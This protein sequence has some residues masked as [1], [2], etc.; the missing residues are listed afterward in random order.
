MQVTRSY[1]SYLLHAKGRH[2]IHSPFVYE[3]V[4]KCLTTKID[5]N[6]KVQLKL[7]YAQL[8]KNNTLLTIN[9]LGAGSNFTQQQKTVSRIFKNASSKGIYGNLLY[10]LAGYFKPSNILELG[11]SLGVGTVHLKNGFKNSSVHTVEGCNEIHQS[12]TEQ[13]KYWD[14]KDVA[15][16]NQS[17]ANFIPNFTEKVDLI[18]LDGHHEQNATKRYLEQLLNNAHSETLFILDDIRW[19]KDMWNCW[20]SICTDE[21]FHVT[22]DIGRMGLFWLRPHQTKEHFVLRPFIIKTPWF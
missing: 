8:R 1:W 12:A 20:E 11:T 19:S 2:G 6:F 10:R 14:F 17:F 22:I 15:L 21:R 3:L 4:D 9:D 16:Y 18:Y 7:W 5:K 13:L